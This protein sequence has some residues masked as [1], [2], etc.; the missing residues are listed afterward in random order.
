MLW[1]SLLCAVF[2]FVSV[3]LALKLILI[4]REIKCICLQFLIG[5]SRVMIQTP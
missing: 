4:R 2:A 5:S 1:L 3:I